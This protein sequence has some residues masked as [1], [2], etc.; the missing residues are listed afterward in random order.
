MAHGVDW[1]IRYADIAP[2]YDHVERYIGVSGTAE[3]LSQVPD[4]QFLPGMPLN[5]AERQVQANLAKRYGRERV[6]TIGRC[7][8]LTKP[9]GGRAACGYCG[10]CERGCT[11]LLAT[12]TACM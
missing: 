4:G 10:V 11:H 5:V 8:I 9:H 2:W 1:P 6:L 3:G 7:A 12:S